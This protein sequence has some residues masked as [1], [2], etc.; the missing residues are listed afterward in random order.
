MRLS[1]NF[2]ICI[3]FP[4][5]WIFYPRK[6]LKLCVPSRIKIPRK[7]FAWQKH[8]GNDA[9]AIEYTTKRFSGRMI[10]LSKNTRLPF[11]SMVNSSTEKIGK[12]SKKARFQQRV[13]IKKNVLDYLKSKK[14]IGFLL[15]AGKTT[16][17]NSS[18]G[19]NSIFG[20]TRNFALK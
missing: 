10:C 11:L 20:V 12:T 13:W 8:C 1:C 15:M 14:R 6:A 7:N 2:I 18:I 17:F 9:I 19:A 5:L 16:L 3:N 4:K